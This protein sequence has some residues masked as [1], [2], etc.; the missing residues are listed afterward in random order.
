MP[1]LFTKSENKES[2]DTFVDVE[3]IHTSP[4]Q[5]RKTFSDRATQELSESIKVHGVLQ[6]LLCVKSEDGYSLVAGERRLR[7]AKLAGLK[8]VPVTVLDKSARECAEIALI[9]NV[10]RENL[11]FFEEAEGYA[12]LID[13]F[14]FTQSEIAKRIS[15]KQSTV[16]N[17][18]RLLK[19]PQ[20]ARVI[21]C[22]NGLTERHARQLLRIKDRDTLYSVLDYVV[23]KK[24]NV[25]QTEKYI[26]EKLTP[27]P[28]LPQRSG[29]V[30]DVRIFVNTINKAV[31]LI[32]KAG[33][34]PEC[35]LTERDGFVEYIIKIP[36][37]S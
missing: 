35:E 4:D 37:T 27:P 15:K 1:F 18:L 36:K 13:E 25:S 19:L 17:K 33:I 26:T 24:L 30:R 11:T 31:D 10:Q 29:K 34:K 20:T 6:P 2:A 21:I 28:T 9:E 14:S 8:S 32:K 22:A 12:R 7:A 16:S 5:P 3:L 23:Q